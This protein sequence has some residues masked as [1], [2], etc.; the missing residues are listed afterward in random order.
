MGLNV[1][2]PTHTFI[3]ESATGSW[4]L[5]MSAVGMA[6]EPVQYIILLAVVTASFP[7]HM[8]IQPPFPGV[9]NLISTH[10]V[11]GLSCICAGLHKTS[12]LLSCRTQKRVER[13]GKKNEGTSSCR[14]AETCNYLSFF[15]LLFLI[16]A[17]PFFTHSPFPLRI[18]VGGVTTWGDGSVSSAASRAQQMKL[19]WPLKFRLAHSR[20]C[21]Q[22]LYI[23]LVLS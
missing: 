5:R 14:L 7:C 19:H 3:T 4:S 10:N 1:N 22:V 20:C 6:K 18:P 23:P 16:L 12:Q 2:I 9:Y 8:T 21:K 17:L 13:R 15:S 11:K